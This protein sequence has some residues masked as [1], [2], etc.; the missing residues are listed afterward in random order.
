MTATA[1]M[2]AQGGPAPTQGNGKDVRPSIIVILCDDMG[3]SDIGCYGGEIPTPNIDQL[4]KNGIRFTHCYNAARCCPSRS[5]LLTGLYPH[6]AGVG[7][8]VYADNGPGYL[9]HL[10]H[11]CVTIAEVLRDAGYRTMM[12]GKWHV[13]NTKGVWPT[14]RG[15]E[16]FFGIHMHIDSYFTVLKDCTVYLDDTEVIPATDAPVNALNPSQEW[17]TTDVF[18]D[19]ALSFVDEAVPSHQPFFLYLAYNSPHF[20]LQAPEENIAKFSGK[21]MAGWDRLREEKLA[22]MKKLGIVPQDTALSPS[23]NTPWSAL[24]ERD[25]RELDFRR[26]IY[27]AQIDRMDQNIGRLAKRLEQLGVLDNTVIMFLSDNGCSAEIGMFGLHWPEYQ[28]AN[29]SQWRREGGW[30]TSQGQAWANASNTP[31]RLYKR[32]VHEGGIITPLIVHWP[33]GVKQPGRL[34]HEVTHIVDIMATCCDLA[35]TQYP[36]TFGGRKLRPLR[37]KS[38]APLFH[39]QPR[40][41]H[42]AI[43]WEHEK[44][45]AVRCGKWK[46]VSKDDKKIVWELYDLD[47]DPTELNDLAVQRPDT[48]QELKTRWEA[49]ACQTHV[50]PWPEDR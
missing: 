45:A 24:T 14:D 11:E 15:F 33:R 49:W 23:M 1:A 39:G 44:H 36:E 20:P 28:I 41:G 38:L 37:G 13:G 5:S 2:M 8:M 18:T 22:R 40:E 3:Y 25:Q 47:A 7:D 21:H 27:A 6:E 16:R 30:A 26:A 32:W 9:G 34:S 35:N 12:S 17:Y 31:Y 43:L 10:N 48:V 50:L 46:L 19:Y 42:D 4:G 29:Y